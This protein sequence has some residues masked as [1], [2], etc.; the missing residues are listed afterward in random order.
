MLSLLL[1]VLG[2]A[3]AVQEPEPTPLPGLI[4]L[5]ITFKNGERLVKQLR[6]DQVQEFVVDEENI[7]ICTTSYKLTGN[8]GYTCTYSGATCA[9]AAAQMYESLATIAC[10]ILHVQIHALQVSNVN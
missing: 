8:Q 7:L 2:H 5:D 10:P 4:V 1:S 3:G 9:E 6:P